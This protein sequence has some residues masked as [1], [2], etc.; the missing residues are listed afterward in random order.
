MISLSAD[1]LVAPWTATFGVQASSSTTSSYSYFALASALRN[2]TA[3][4][5]ELRPPSPLTETPPV[6]GPMNPT[7]TL[8]FASTGAAVSHSAA[9]ADIA[10]TPYFIMVTSPAGHAEPVSIL[11]GLSAG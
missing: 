6:R 4:S 9:N 2:F 8:S 11:D 5:A 7:L 1:I 3:R 10:T